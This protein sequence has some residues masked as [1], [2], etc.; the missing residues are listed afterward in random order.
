[1]LRA[2]REVALRGLTETIYAM[3]SNQKVKRQN[4]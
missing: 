2:A 4:A 1:M 3:T